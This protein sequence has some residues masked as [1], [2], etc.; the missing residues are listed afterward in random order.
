MPAKTLLGDLSDEEECD[1]V[2][3][4][5]SSYDHSMN[6]TIPLEERLASLLN[7]SND[8]TFEGVKRLSAMYLISG[9]SVLEKYL[10]ALVSVN[11]PSMVKLEAAK[12]LCA[13]SANKKKREPRSYE[14]L[15]TVCCN[16]SDIPTPCKIDT[17]Y[18]LMNYFPQRK[19]SMSHFT[20]VLKD[21]T[22]DCD[23]RYKAVLTIET[24]VDKGEF[25]IRESCLIF[26]T[27]LDNMTM[28][29]I[30]ACQ[31]LLQKHYKNVDVGKLETILMTFAQD[32]DLDYNLRADAADVILTLG[33]EESKNNAREVILLL[34]FENRAVKTVFN[35][36]QNV[37]NRAIED[38]VLEILEFLAE[39]PS[40]KVGGSKNGVIISFRE[41][42]EKILN[43]S[44]EKE[45]SEDDQ[46]MINIS[47][48][49]ITM[50]RA[51]FS[52]FSC[53]LS[54]VLVKVW[55]YTEEHKSGIDMRDRL[56]EELVEMAGTCSSGFVSRLCNTISGFGKFNI[57]ISWEDQ[58]VANF[59]GRL[60][61]RAKYIS[62][63]TADRK[64]TKDVVSMYLK[65]TTGLTL[66]ETMYTLV[67]KEMFSNSE[68]PTMKKVFNQAIKQILESD[69]WR[70]RKLGLIKK[71]EAEAVDCFRDNIITEM[72][73]PPSA[74]YDRRH[75]LKFFRDNFLSIREEM[76][77]EFEEHI[78]DTDFDLYF[79]K[80]IIAYE[81]QR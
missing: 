39:L 36:A 72:A 50:D 52:K 59:N 12:V 45:L 47:L 26:A 69:E 2:I 3:E 37:H 76:W 35:N 32:P 49:R 75:F 58:I 57:R 30:L 38:S 6:L 81:G 14:A 79:R 29:R 33:C 54:N 63:S 19:N 16:M 56:I 25:F 51:I 15:N 41:V 17:I 64:W 67:K 61:A 74:N 65:D 46:K 23:Y 20:R 28:Y 62:L 40:M 43:L 13:V 73:L 53:S 4:H 18:I 11:I 27:D 66:K 9:T 34:G 44:V 70:G 77:M 7:C 55:S 42:K 10:F 71:Y 78:A 60:N 24:R 68:Q 80:A 21:H 8:L 48:N 31:Y 5:E 22:L 1:I